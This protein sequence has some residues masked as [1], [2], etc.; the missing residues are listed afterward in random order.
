MEAATTHHSNSNEF[1]PK[2]A[3]GAERVNLLEGWSI[4][5]KSKQHFKADES[6]IIKLDKIPWINKSTE[7]VEH[8]STE[9]VMYS[10]E[11]AGLVGSQIEMSKELKELQAQISLHLNPYEAEIVSNRLDILDEKVWMNAA[12]INDIRALVLD[13]DM[14]YSRYQYTQ[15]EVLKSLTADYTPNNN[16]VLRV[17]K[18]MANHRP[19]PHIA[20]TIYRQSQGIVRILIAGEL[21]REIPSPPPT[22]EGV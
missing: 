9:T 10:L 21:G 12:L 15:E 6:R 3:I 22:L 1:T 7:R 17:L 5:K 2:N 4:L 8:R 20:S 16:T 18:Q 11:L 13:A 14:I 19:T